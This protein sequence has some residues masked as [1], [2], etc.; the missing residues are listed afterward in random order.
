MTK[1]ETP[2]ELTLGISPCPNDVFIFGALMLGRVMPNS[3]SLR[4]YLEDVQTLN[5]WAQ[6]EQLDVLKISCAA[7]SLCRPSYEML[8][9]GG[10]LGRGVG[11]LLLSAD[12]QWSPERTTLVPGEHTTANLLLDFYAKAPLNK[13][14]L[15]F[16]ALYSA[17][18]NGEARQGV[19]IHEKRFTYQK[20]GLYLIQDLGT[21]WEEKTGYPIPLGCIVARRSLGVAPSITELIRKSLQYAYAHEE[22]IFALCKQHAKDLQDNVIAS[23]IHLYVNAYSYDLG[24]EGQKA[25]EYL[26]ETIQNMQRAKSCF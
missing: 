4:F 21:Y 12:G 8:P 10:A 1:L 20:D 16:D 13:V 24:L 15:P 3:F 5:L 7:Y 25:V 19:V 2:P 6:E 23:H 14:F 18:C 22:E 17:L 26:L 9:A 11:P